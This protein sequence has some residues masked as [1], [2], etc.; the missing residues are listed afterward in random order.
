MREREMGDPVDIDEKTVE[1]ISDN[2]DGGDYSLN[3]S[4]LPSPEQEQK[5]SGYHNAEQSFDTG[6]KAWL[7]VLGSH[8]LFFNSWYAL[9]LCLPL[10][11]SPANESSSV[12]RGI[13]NTF[14]CFQTYYEQEILSHMSPSSISWIGSIQSF[15]L[16]LIGVISGP[17]FDAGYFQILLLG[18]SFLIPFGLMMTSLSSQYWQFMLAQGICIGLGCGMLFVP[19]VAV[20][21]QYFRHKRG[22]ANGIAA[23]G[24]SI[25]GVIYPIMFRQLQQQVGFS[26]ATRTLGFVSLGTCCI[27]LAV[28]RMRFKP[29]EKRALIQLSA[30]KELQFDL[31]CLATFLGF[32]GFYN[33]L[34]YVQPWAIQ[35]GILDENLGFYLVPM[36]NAA[37]TFGRVTPNMLA[38][39]TG[40]INILTP[41]ATVTCILAFG[42]I[43]IKSSSGIIVLTILYGFFSGG[44]VS[45]PPMV[46]MTITKDMRN[47]GT[48]LGMNF[49]ITS[50][51]LLVGTPI[52]GAIL[53][54]SQQYLGVQLFCALCLLICALTLASLRLTRSGLKL[55]FRT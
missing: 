12:P 7:Q 49:G 34:F 30:F 39:Y 48:R 53:H 21:P 54:N 9:H 33:F 23:S 52:G 36:L 35:T 55:V 50:I 46:M 47:F 1:P 42:W 13:I 3:D 26:W 15:L 5:D 8:F 43:G 31:F 14:G 2:K 19:S 4:D 18:G 27:S 29:T 44:F 6:V 45:L 20:L 22:L 40:P 51:A 32:L 17:L 38:D 16:M 10:F 25:G 37:S 24:S 11:L 41:A 28:S